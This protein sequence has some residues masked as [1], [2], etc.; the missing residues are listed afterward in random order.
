M[1]TAE[2]TLA[3]GVDVEVRD[4]VAEIRIDLPNRPVN[5]LSARMVEE[6]TAVLERL[7][8]GRDGA[9]A[10]I[11]VS[12]KPGVWI[13]GADVEQLREIRTAADGEALSRSAHELLGRLENLRLP[14][15][16][17]I[18]GAALGGGL[19]VALACTYRIASDGPKTKLALP[20]V[21]L[22]LLPGAGGTQRLPR[23][24]GLR[25]AL[26]LMLTGK[27]LDGRRAR[28]MGL[29][30]E[31]VPQAILEA[32][33]REAAVE[34][35]ER[36]LEP[37][38]GRPRGSP[39]WMENLPGLRNFILHK[40]RQGV[41][42]KTHGLYPAPLRI[43]EVVTHG[44]DQ[45]LDEGLRLEARAFGELT[46]TPEARSLT[47]L[48]F[49]STAAKNEPMLPE[50]ARPADVERV[51]IVGAGFMGAGI[52]T[53]SAESGMRVRLKD[54]SPEAVAKGVALTQKSIRKRASR[55]RR[56]EYELVQL[57]D[58]VEGTAEYTG[59]GSME[60]VVEAVFEDLELK[61]RVLREIEAASSEETVLASNT[62]TIPI[63]ELAE[64][65]SRPEKVIGLHFFSPVEKMPLVEIIVTPRTDP[66][67]AAT[68]HAYSKRIGKTPIIVNDAPGFY[69]NR[70]LGPYMNEAALLLQ[71]GVRMEEIDAAMVAWGFP[72]GP[73]T[74][75]DEVGLDVAAK[76]GQIL[77]DAFSDRLQPNS[78]LPKMLEDGRKGRK[79]EHGF[80]RYADGK[81]GDPDASVYTLIGV[82][83]ESMTSRHQI[84][85]RLYL[86]MI[87][88][89]V[90]CL[91]DGVLRSARDGDVGAVF[92]IGF[93]PFRGGP[94]WYLDQTGPLAV[95]ERLRALERA[96][97]NRFAPAPLLVE[98]AERGEG[99]HGHQPVSAS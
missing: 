98:K 56:P 14:V 60:L 78:V 53:V 72:V 8:S 93:A 81:K 55:R 67:V 39:Q 36:R 26:E 86:G 25:E 63:A 66:S 54:V 99:F 61:Q 51:G 84:Q 9:R 44:L 33:A 73:I 75:Y 69:V 30:D 64:A 40:A 6:F 74:L 17:A 96:H 45:R 23:L 3:H 27:Q 2:S 80:Y 11:I 89:A 22:G 31:V 87:N 70:I 49:A 13:A 79:N 94:F 5:V 38:A 19:E 83:P 1:S 28:R 52:A 42:E 58:R 21:Q 24:V 15:V 68:C 41:L 65:V 37:R 12:G 18:D 76:S 91:E 34:I 82:T 59:F 62:S 50:G 46:V 57:V 7:E 20:E 16:A 4:G 48:F 92:G 77:A 90:R 71:E 43:L 95:V 97:G 47:H 35:A 88:E 29:V 85:D 10:A 32:R